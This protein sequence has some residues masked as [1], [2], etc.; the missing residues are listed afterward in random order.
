M[1]ATQFPITDLTSPL[2]LN[3]VGKNSNNPLD[4]FNP[5]LYSSMPLSFPNSNGLPN[6]QTSSLISN[7]TNP[8]AAMSATNLHGPLP[9][10][11]TLS[12][13]AA[14]PSANNPNTMV[15]A[16]INQLGGYYSNGRPLNEEL[17]KKIIS[18]SRKNIRPCE[19]SRRLKVSHGCVSKI[20]SRFHKTG[21]IKPGII[22]GS[23]PRVAKDF[24]IQKICSLKRE[25]PQ[26]FA[27]EIR[28][29]L[30]DQKV[31]GD[32]QAPSISSINRILRQNYKKIDENLKN[33]AAL[34][35][36]QAQALLQ[37]QANAAVA[38][39]ASAS[40]SASVSNP[41]VNLNLPTFGDYNTQKLI[42]AAAQVS[43]QLHVLPQANESN[44]LD[45]PNP[46]VNLPPITDDNQN[47]LLKI[48]EVQIFRCK[49]PELTDFEK[50]LLVIE[51]LEQ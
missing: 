48:P 3:L 40:A 9:T 27:W 47:P 36:L 45:L 28:K 13:N 29:K 32:A 19:I 1:D 16:G 24:I 30:E 46:A 26:L 6:F 5:N 25:N 39:A 18:M 43:G 20:L 41:N 37:N 21:S 35:N 11:P 2:N 33:Q 51:R 12:N 8:L 7:S 38:A 42:C 17:R 49:S 14:P 10:L 31:C 4:A 15:S 50:D 44:L 34:H 22:G 23:R